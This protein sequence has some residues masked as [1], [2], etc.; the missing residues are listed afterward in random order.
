MVR[1][2]GGR[3]ALCLVT[4]LGALA[5]LGLCCS[6]ALGAVV[7][8]VPD[9]LLVK[10]RPGTPASQVARAHANARARILDEISQIGVQIVGL[11]TSVP[12]QRAIGIYA[13][14]PNVEFVEPDCVVEPDAVPNDPQYPSQW[15]LP[16]IAAPTAWDSTTGGSSVI[17][18]ILD[19]GVN[20]NHADLAPKMVPGWN[21]YDNS[22]NTADVYGH[23]TAVAGTAAACANNGIGVASVAWDC[24]I[25][26]IRISDTSGYGYY[27]T[28]AS[29]LT[30]AADHGA[31]VANISYEFSGAS[32]V[33]EGAK[34]FQSK[35][36]VVTISAGNAGTALTLPDNPYVLTVGATDGSDNLASWSNTGPVIDIVAPGVSILTT[37]S[38]GG[39]AAYSGTSLSAPVA[40]GVVALVIS[41]NPTLSGQQA[42]DIVK[43]SADDLGTIGWDPRFGF[44]RV[45]AARAVA[46]AVTAPSDTQPPT[47]AFSSPTP[48]AQV[49][50]TVQVQVAA[51]DNVAVAWVSVS[52]D[53]IA[54]G[55]D[56]S[57]PYLF[58]WDT[59]AQ[60]NGEHSLSATA[61]D[62]S[63]NSATAQIAVSVSNAVSTTDTVA[64]EV[65]ILSAAASPPRVA[66]F[67]TVQV[68]ATD[69]VAVT[70]VE[71]YVNQVLQA[72]STTA[73]YSFKLNT[74]KWAPG[75]Y[76]LQARAYDAAGNSAWSQPV[77][78]VK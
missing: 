77:T 16:K 67:L 61:R 71:L 17:I 66:S 32:T 9:R 68:T 1:T 52:V 41:A 13:H 54:L 39:Y 63:G 33:S 58:S 20:G 26:P 12:L 11:P 23:G 76:L 42:Q 8:Y 31:R 65:A 69:N 55:T 5:F 38:G 49:S 57:A 74:R 78:F 35:G 40:A 19:T 22:S 3:A 21:A 28:A 59:T 37:A 2:L 72:T 70:R 47:V 50:G 4:A 51:W 36:G 46:L 27:S 24:R 64:P 18:A 34:Y 14:N 10:F 73:P 45:N 15:H 62:A 60:A 7:G 75:S 48:G 29:G 44:G 30:W 43:Q 6:S 53:G 25:M 56:T